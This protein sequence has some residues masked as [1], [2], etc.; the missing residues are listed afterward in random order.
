[1][2]KAQMAAMLA[3]G[4]I[5]RSPGRSLALLPPRKSYKRFLAGAK[6]AFAVSMPAA[7][8]FPRFSASFKTASSCC[9]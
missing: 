9:C 1:M 5:S 3:V 8:L 6:A 4:E 2:R 7:T